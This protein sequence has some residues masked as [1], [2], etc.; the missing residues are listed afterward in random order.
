[1]I[2]QT[3]FWW[4][5]LVAPHVLLLWILVALWRKGL[6]KQH[7]IFFCYITYEVLQFPF[8]LYTI[9]S[10]SISDDV[11]WKLCAVLLLGSVFLRFGVIYELF[12][13]LSRAYPS[14]ERFSKFLFRSLTAVLLFIAVGLIAS[15]WPG[16]VHQLT[17]FITYV[18]DRGANVLQLGLLLGLFGIANFFGLSWRKHVFGITLGFAMYLSVQLMATAIQAE[19]GYIK[20]FDYITMATFHASVLVWLLYV[21]VPEPQT[22]L[23]SVPDSADVAAWNREVE[24]LLQPK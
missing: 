12:H 18:L 19:W 4:Y 9:L 2:I 15:A 6:D 10:R 22:A 8:V 23:T 14:L 5:L 17:R 11:Y 1:M 3:S 16:N 24:R 13:N 7:R 21:L 20:V